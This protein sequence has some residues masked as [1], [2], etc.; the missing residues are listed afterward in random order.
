MSAL[1]IKNG[2]TCTLNIQIG[3]HLGWFTVMKNTGCC[4]RNLEHTFS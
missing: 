2:D 4:R 3:H 1:K